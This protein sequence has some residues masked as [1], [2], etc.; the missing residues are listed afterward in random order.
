MAP[1]LTLA[2]PLMVSVGATL[3]TVTATVLPATN[4][5]SSFVAVA[6]IVQFA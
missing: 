4:V 1:S 2:A 3:F 5:L 6:L